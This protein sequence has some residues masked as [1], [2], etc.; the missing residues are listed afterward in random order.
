MRGRVKT[1]IATA[2][3]EAKGDIVKSIYVKDLRDGDDLLNEPFLLQDVIHRETKDGRP[4]LLGT[5]RDRTGEIGGVFWDVPADVEG[6]IRPGTVTLVTGRVNSYKN[7]LQINTT[8]LNL[9]TPEDM[10]Q[11]LPS[12]SRPVQEMIGELRQLVSGLVEPWQRLVSHLLLDPEFL[13]VF[14]NAPAARV[15]HHAYIGGLLEHTLSMA[16]I[17]GYLSKHYPYVN[18]DLLIA[19]VLLHDMG[20]A[21]EY[22]T[23]PAFNFTDDGRLVGHVVRAIVMVEQGVHELGGFQHEEVRLL[24]HMIASHHGRNEWGAPVEPKT[25][26]AILLHQI[27]MIDS[28]AQGYYD[29]L[30]SDIGGSLWTSRYSPMFGSDLRRPPNF[31]G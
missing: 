12:S 1:K 30:R 21:H 2:F 5:Y 20:K 9:Y 28:R 15:M 8:D 22:D 17:A 13:P 7:A 6:W 25:L 16:T 24:V 31:L 19:G 29:H 18:K 11:F 26:E 27:D 23:G 10:S 4:Y 3:T 14:A